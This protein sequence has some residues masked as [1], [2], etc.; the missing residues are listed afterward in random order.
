MLLERDRPSQF[1]V[2]LSDTLRV[3]TCDPVKCDRL[4]YPSVVIREWASIHAAMRIHLL[5]QLP[6]RPT[7]FTP[8]RSFQFLLT[9]SF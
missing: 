8:N 3:G 5:T 2:S 7:A 9:V 1:G 4:R 6:V